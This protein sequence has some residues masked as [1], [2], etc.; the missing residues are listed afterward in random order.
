MAVQRAEQLTVPEDAPVV[1]RE[2]TSE[3]WPRPRLFDVDEYYRMAEAGI[4][5]PDERVELIEGEI[6]VMSPIGSRHLSAVVRLTK[7]FVVRLVG[8]AEFSIQNPVQ[9]RRRVEPEPD[10][11]ILRLQPGVSRPYESAHPG[12]NDVLLVVEVAETSVA[13]DLGEKA[14]M[15][16]RYGI[17]ELWVLDLPADR[18]VI[19]REPTANGYA[20]VQE[21]PR[22]Q[23]ISPV[24]FADTSFS[25]D[26]LLGPPASAEDSAATEDEA[27]GTE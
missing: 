12:P 2:A 16:A 1:R 23:S 14:D 27:A 6:L 21:L 22:G 3:G 10:V 19:H 25:A 8:L 13:F 26:E 4:L 5:R 17:P 7:L 15:Y 9:L 11:A 18:A 24:A 20:S